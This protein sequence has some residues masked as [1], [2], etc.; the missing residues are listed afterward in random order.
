VTVWTDPD[1]LAAMVGP[2]VTVD[3]ADEW[4]I[5]C[6]DAAN[7]AA[8]RKRAEAGYVDDPDPA[9]PAPSP[10]VAMGAT[11]WAAALWRER[12]STDSYQSF[13]E[14]ETFAPTGGSWGTIKRL[15][16][17][18]RAQVDATVTPTAGAVAVLRR[19]RRAWIR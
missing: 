6:C 5:A 19:R 7:A 17:I 16:G 12:A 14:L 4:V 3:P 18:G 1:A 10:D 2:G 13:D 11:I 9:A 8:F 15:L